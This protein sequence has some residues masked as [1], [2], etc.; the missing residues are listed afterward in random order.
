M[1]TGAFGENFPYSNFHDLNMDWIIKIAKDFLD[2]YTHIQEVIANGEE[3]LQNLTTSGLEQ[4]QTKADTLEALLQQWYDTHSEDIANQ[5][6]D[7]LE[8][9][10]NWYTEHSQ[11]I[12]NK[13]EDAVNS[14]NEQAVAIGQEVIDSIPQD[15]S[16]VSLRAIENSNA[17]LK[18]AKTD[19]LEY[20][21]NK[22][23]FS[24]NSAEGLTFSPAVGGLKVTGTQTNIALKTI[25]E[26]SLPSFLQ[27]NVKYCIEF[28]HDKPV[29]F[30]IFGYNND[31]VTKTIYNNDSA[32]GYFVIPENFSNHI[33]VRFRFPSNGTTWNDTL[34]VHIF[35]PITKTNITPI[36]NLFNMEYVKDC[37][38]SG[39]TV[40]TD[41]RNGTITVNGTAYANVEMYITDEFTGLHQV[42][43]SGGARGGN[44]STYYIGIYEEGA[45]RIDFLDGSEDTYKIVTLDPTKTYTG[46]I[47]VLRGVTVNNAVFKPIIWG[48]EYL[49]NISTRIQEGILNYRYYR[50][51]CSIA[52]CGSK[53]I[54]DC[55]AL[56]LFN[57]LTSTYTR[58]LSGTFS[59]HID[60]DIESVRYIHFN[61]SNFTLNSTFDANT[62]ASVGSK[63]V[64]PFLDRG[65]IAD[66]RMIQ[67]GYIKLGTP[68]HVNFK[69][70]GFDAYSGYSN[71]EDVKVAEQAYMFTT[72][73]TKYYMHDKES[74][75]FQL[76]QN[77]ANVT[78]K[79]ILMIG[80][81]FIARGFI[82]HYLSQFE[83][84]LQFIGTHDTLY[85][86]YKS[87]GVS[88]S[89][90]Y[91][92]TD[93]STSP[94][95]FNGALD[96]S[97][98]LNVNNLP[99]PDYIIINSAINHTR[100]YDSEHGSYLSQLN[101]LINMIR[102][103]STS[104]KIYVTYGANYAMTIPST[105]GY[106]N[107][108]E[109]EVL[110]C[111]N[112]VYDT[113]NTIIIPVNQCLV[114]EL[115]YTKGTYNYYGHQIDMFDDCVHP[116]E[117]TG[118]KKIS[119]MIYNYLGM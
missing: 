93:P 79:K 56:R 89:R 31:N 55:D 1:N 104:I 42:I 107:G 100:Y 94:F 38:D 85:Y 111:T 8:D 106:P 2:Q 21:L 90:L 37:I 28:P 11:D 17:L 109:L 22:F 70:A 84:T 113:E 71:P 10:N 119:E 18:Y 6:A 80:D 97:A 103:F 19:N 95:Y 87:E 81:S 73:G 12:A 75:S 99:T 67:Q 30:Q 5:L 41:K 62:I 58:S 52:V 92:F 9:L 77:T 59:L 88:G 32:S 20:F 74:L 112:S 54:I 45:G 118:F 91:Y 40:T 57:V 76:L 101:Q 64:R 65:I 46:R 116:E 16:D 53:I 108:R 44:R 78:N 114:D 4:L 3:S 14:F 66:H 29:Q 23:S 72:P 26:G 39:I 24:E 68:Y 33:L 117:T 61:G 83:P 7:A 34:Y 105:Y 47:Y 86:S 102:S 115:D 27:T 35:N 51:Y 48:N 63:L 25:Y 36:V 82:Q 98:Y 96:F 43:M 110:K 15:Y 69:R 60:D 50:G 49:Y 13:L